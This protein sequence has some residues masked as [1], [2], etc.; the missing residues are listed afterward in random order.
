MNKETYHTPRTDKQRIS[1]LQRKVMKLE[2]E[3]KEHKQLNTDLHLR[4]KEYKT[5]VREM[6]ENMEKMKDLTREQTPMYML[7]TLETCYSI[8]DG[9]VAIHVLK[10]LRNVIKFLK[11]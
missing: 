1:E 4:H 5:S 7:D 9:T 11:Q 8:L 2:T 10:D 6:F 3:N